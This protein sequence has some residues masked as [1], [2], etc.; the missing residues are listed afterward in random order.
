MID[1]AI[2]GLGWWGKNLVNAVQGKGSGLRFTMGVT[3]ELDETRAYAA[4]AG[5]T[6]AGRLEDVL[7]EPAV[8]AVVL[9]TPHSLHADQIVAAARAGKHVF[10]EKPLALNAAD[11]RR[12]IEACTSRGLALGV[13]Q[14]KRFWPSMA[15][16]REI[17]SSGRL[18]QLLHVEGHY[19]NL[20]SSKFFSDWRDSPAES[21]AGGLT[22][23]GIHIIDAFVALMGPA[24]R[25]SASV[26]SL[27]AG[28]DPRDATTVSVRFANGLN[29]TFA[30]VR[31]TP[32]YWR[33][34]VFGDEG[35]AEAIGE[36]E[37]IVRDRTGA[38]VRHLFPPVDSLK[39]ELEAFARA[40]AADTAAARYPI[41]PSDMFATIALF[42]AVVTSIE[43]D[44]PVEVTS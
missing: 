33:V 12:A 3:K 19:S 32:L 22:G 23:T 27:R 38:V 36:N 25:V 39:A 35:S 28:K 1:A 34:H 31:A 16:L 5:L 11:A 17:V 4:A 40:I 21:P 37:L 6:L 42:E 9:A 13:G 10:C 7:G 43:T 20:H 15:H 24:T 18:G 14:N 44:Q 29:G 2:V 8:K 26:A 30:M 41:S